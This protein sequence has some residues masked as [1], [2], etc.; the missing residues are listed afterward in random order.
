MLEYFGVE[1]KAPS[2]PQ[3]SMA[4]TFVRTAGQLL[5]TRSLAV[6]ELEEFTS[7]D[8]LKMGDKTLHVY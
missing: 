3:P 7:G 2:S 4:N 8:I 5:F 1:M 6:V